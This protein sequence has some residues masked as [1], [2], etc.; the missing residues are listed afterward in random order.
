MNEAE[1]VR[2]EVERLRK[3][4]KKDVL[5]C[6]DLMKYYNVGKSN[7]RNLMN[8][9]NFP[10]TVIGRRKVITLHNLVIFEFQRNKSL[11]NSN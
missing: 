5:T 10:T 1:L 11:L 3:V 6:E 9:E 8:S 4:F 2:Q 7:I